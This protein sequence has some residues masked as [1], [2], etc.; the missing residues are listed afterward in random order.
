MHCHTKARR[1]N[2]KYF[3]C[4][5]DRNSFSGFGFNEKTST[6]SKK[7]SLFATSILSTISLVFVKCFF[8]R[9]I[10]P[11]IRIG[12]ESGKASEVIEKKGFEACDELS[13]IEARIEAL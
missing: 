4:T 5:S 12:A 7:T 6:R 3:L 9:V 1:K 8:L 11:S 10:K 2:R 13:R